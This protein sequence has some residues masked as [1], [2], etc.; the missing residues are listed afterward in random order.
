MVL[1][2]AVVAEWPTC[3]HSASALLQF[4]EELSV[5]L[6]QRLADRF[7]GQFVCSPVRSLSSSSSQQCAGNSYPPAGF[8]YVAATLVALAHLLYYVMLLMGGR[9]SE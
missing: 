5:V 6:P 4:L 2:H 3:L 7:R 9:D 8:T 1:A